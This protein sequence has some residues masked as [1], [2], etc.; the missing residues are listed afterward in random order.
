MKPCHSWGYGSKQG[1]G[2]SG[3][4][5][6]WHIFSPNSIF[7]WSYRTSFMWCFLFKNNGNI[8]S[9]SYSW[10]FCGSAGKHSLHFYYSST[11][12]CM[13]SWQCKGHDFCHI[14][15]T[16]K[17]VHRTTP[18]ITTPSKYLQITIIQHEQ[19]NIFKRV[20]REHTI[21]HTQWP[22]TSM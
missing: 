4:G 7:R 18:T 3:V 14:I 20:R 2:S 1:T 6:N 5:R 8:C 19:H 10:C 16:Y 21:H 13:G 15:I 11:H 9:T 12:L 17:F 22:Y